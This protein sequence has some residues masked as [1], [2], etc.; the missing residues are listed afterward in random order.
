MNIPD[1]ISESLEILKF[2]AADPYP[3]SSGTFLDLWSGINISDLQYCWN[4]KLS[5]QWLAQKKVT[6]YFYNLKYYKKQS[7][8]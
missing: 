6:T 7:M 5:H 8:D 3:G 4:H 2:F 1:H